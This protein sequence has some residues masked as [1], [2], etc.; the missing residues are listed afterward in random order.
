MN[1]AL[2]EGTVAHGRNHDVDHRFTIPLYMLY[3]DLSEIPELFDNFPGWTANRPGLVRFDRSDHLGSDPESLQNSVRGRVADE[4]GRRPEGPIRLL[5]QLRHF[6]YCFNPVSFYYCF[7][8]NDDRLET[9]IAEVH[10][11]PWNEEHVYV[12]DRHSGQENDGRLHFRFDK[13]FHVSPFLP[14][15]T[16]Y[17]MSVSRPGENLSVSIDSHRKDQRIFHASME[18]QRKPFTPI[19]AYWQM[20]KYP[21]VSL[22]VIGRIYFEALRLWWKGARFHSHPEVSRA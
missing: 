22:Q 7:D 4:I 15:E 16:Y 13:E 9:I 3:L 12:L 10:N 6:G 11:T 21:A 1:S 2:Y 19:N 8:R 5:T 14:M 17:E 18:M 20:L